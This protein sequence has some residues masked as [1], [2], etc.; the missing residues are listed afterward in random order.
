M[1]G[2]SIVAEGRKEGKKRG[3]R[4]CASS[5]ASTLESEVELIDLSG[6]KGE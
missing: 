1:S 3:D 6:N 4:P 5:E 2:G